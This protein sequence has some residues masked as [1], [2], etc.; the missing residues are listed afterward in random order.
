MRLLLDTHVALWAL[1][2]PARL[3]RRTRAAIARAQILVVSVVSPWELAIKQALG[4]VRLQ[5]PLAHVVR[6]LV[7]DLAASVLDVSLEHVL[8][9]E[10]LPAHHGDPFDRL[11]I[12]QAQVER[13]TIATS[14]RHFAA[15]GVPLLEV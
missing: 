10:A 5:R 8:A 4:K 9:V 12:A 13:L 14:D 6:A 15:Y 1:Q 2:E 11:L 7:D 3:S